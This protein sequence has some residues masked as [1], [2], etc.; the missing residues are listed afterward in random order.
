MQK[1]LH[2]MTSSRHTTKINNIV[3]L[4]LENVLFSFEEFDLSCCLLLSWVNPM[5][6]DL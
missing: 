2:N 5:F 1:V 3:F 4:D 6:T